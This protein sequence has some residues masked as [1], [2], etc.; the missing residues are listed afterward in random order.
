[1]K[2]PS[3]IAKY[4]KPL[5]HELS[6]RPLRARVKGENYSAPSP[7]SSPV[8]GEDVGFRITAAIIFAFTLLFLTD[9]TAQHDDWLSYYPAVSRLQGKLTKV[10]K[11]GKPSYGDNPDKDEKVEVAILILP[12]PIRIRART[13]SSVN[14]ESV[15]NVSFVQLIFPAEV[16]GNYSKYL[17]KD[18]VVAGTLV[19]GRTGEHFTDV[20]MT[21]KAVN[22]TGKPM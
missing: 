21:I 2:S 9:A 19:R 11:Y 15:T 12:T 7:H 16:D 3:Q 22:P 8:K 6:P 10:S 4:P 1:M 13:T 17:D 5:S 14:N 18:I 20:V